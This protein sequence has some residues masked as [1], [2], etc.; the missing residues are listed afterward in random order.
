[1]ENNIYVLTYIQVC[2]WI[3]RLKRWHIKHRAKLLLSYQFDLNDINLCSKE[4]S[5]IQ[6]LKVIF[7]VALILFVTGCANFRHLVEEVDM[8]NSVYVEYRVMTDLQHETE[9]FVFVQRQDSSAKTIDGY[10]NAI[11]KASIM[12]AFNT[13]KSEIIF[14]RT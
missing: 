7:T 8:L 10:K 12:E 11:K 2:I 3:L 13:Q 9:S 6:V 5:S 1:M 14:A 4:W